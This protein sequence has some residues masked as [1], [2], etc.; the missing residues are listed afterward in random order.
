MPSFYG[1]VA[2]GALVAVPAF[3][4]ETEPADRQ[5][6]AAAG[7]RVPTAAPIIVTGTPEKGKE[8]LVGSRIPRR[9]VFTSGGIASSTGTRGL[10]PQ[11]GMDPA[12]GVRTFERKECKSDDPGIGEKA[13]CLLIEAQTAISKEKLG[14]ARDLLAYVTLSEEFTPHEHLAAAKWQYRLAADL[15]N[16]ASRETAL[17]QMVGTGAMRASEAL[18]A[19]RALVSLALRDGRRA[20]A[21]ERLVELDGLG[22]ADAQELANL[23]ILTREQEAGDASAIMRRAITMREAANGPVPRGWRDFAENDT[24]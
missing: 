9:A 23:A 7:S 16:H 5:A 17:E 4:Q 22:G 10:V 19:R 2:A 21:R 6:D 12:A 20:L 11:S 1:F 8:V 18:Q 24:P 3:A 14:K 13:A 15:G